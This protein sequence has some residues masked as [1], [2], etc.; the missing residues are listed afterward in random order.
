MYMY[1]YIYIYSMILMQQTDGFRK[2]GYGFE[3][4]AART[5]NFQPT[6][7]TL[8][9]GIKRF[10]QAWNLCCLRRVIYIYICIYMYIHTYIHTHIH[11]YRY[12]A[13]AYSHIHI[14]VRGAYVD[15]PWEISRYYDLDKTDSHDM[16]SIAIL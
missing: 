14:F 4:K 7:Q 10:F 5:C 8:H 3:K 2:S 1:V 15:E 12:T 6:N 16:M 11:T 9:V 13:C